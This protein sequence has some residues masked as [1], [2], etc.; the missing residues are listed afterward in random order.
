[1]TNFRVQLMYKLQYSEFYITNVCNLNCIGCNRFN[2]FAFKGHFK[3]AD[4]AEQYRQWSKLIDIKQIGILGGEPFLNKDLPNFIQGIAECWPNTEI[5]II[6]NGTQFERNK[7]IYDLVKQYNGRIYISVSC[8]NRDE[9]TPLLEQAENWLAPLKS[10]CLTYYKNTWANNYNAVKAPDWPPCDN[11]EDFVLLPEQIQQE[12]LQIHS[13]HPATEMID[14]NNVRLEFFVTNHFNNSTL[15]FDEST[16]HITLHKSNPEDAMNACSFKK[17][18]HFINGKLYKCGPVGILPDFL[19]QFKVNATEEQQ[20]LINNY[21]PAELD[22]NK[23]RLDKF[24]DNLKKAEA[25]PQCSL[26][27]AEVGY[28]LFKASTKKIKINQID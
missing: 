26:C 16:K 9:L 5:V 23:E 24:V 12:C 4:H 8:H 21:Q 15:I 3:W 27:P 28:H 7:H 6:T 11:P 17:C 19:E 18:H 13:L 1:M 10:K 2:N 22:W 25:I 20:Q 14:E